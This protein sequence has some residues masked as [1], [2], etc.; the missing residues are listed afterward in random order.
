MNVHLKMNNSITI[1]EPATKFQPFN[2]FSYIIATWQEPQISSVTYVKRQCK[3]AQV[4]SNALWPPTANGSHTVQEKKE[5]T[6]ETGTEIWTFFH[7][8]VMYKIV[9]THL[10]QGLHRVC[11]A[12]QFLKNK[13]ATRRPFD[14]DTRREKHHSPLCSFFSQC[15]QKKIP[16]RLAYR[17]WSIWSRVCAETTIDKRRKKKQV[18]TRCTRRLGTT[19]QW[20]LKKYT[21]RK[22]M[23]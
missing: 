13:K 14:M 3:H 11:A 20:L 6:N 2:D 16:Y 17:S 1:R 7:S 4:H 10:L 23:K 18:C 8:K 12:N 5:Q 22:C 15:R 19:R 21:W 9:R